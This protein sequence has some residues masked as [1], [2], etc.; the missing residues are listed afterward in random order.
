MGLTETAQFLKNY[1]EIH[2]RNHELAE[3]E[4]AA[5]FARTR[6]PAKPVIIERHT[7]AAPVIWRDGE[8]EIVQTGDGVHVFERT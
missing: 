7:T 6:G 3:P 1:L 4:A 8:S 2:Y 5:H